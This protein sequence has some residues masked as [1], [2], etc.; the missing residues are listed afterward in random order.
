MDLPRGN[1]PIDY[2]GKSDWFSSASC[3]LCAHEP[4]ARATGIGSR[5]SRSG[6]VCVGSVGPA[7]VLD[8]GLL[9]QL[10]DDLLHLLAADLVAQLVVDLLL[11]RGVEGLDAGEGA[12]DQADD[13][14]AG[15]QL[16][17]R[18]D[19]AVVQRE[20]DRLGLRRL[21]LAPLGADAGG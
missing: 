3:R 10:L 1:G 16:D 6:L 15:G 19:L 20:Q 21:D 13:V 9:L 17:E 12:L 4:G 8:D 18:A 11:G 14:E 2:T 7:S 5:R